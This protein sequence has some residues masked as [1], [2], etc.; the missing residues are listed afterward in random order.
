MA[1]KDAKAQSFWK[2]VEVLNLVTL[3]TISF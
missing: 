3:L 2:F 1:R